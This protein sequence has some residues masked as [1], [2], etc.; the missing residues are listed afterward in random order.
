MRILPFKKFLNFL[1]LL[2][3]SQSLL[4][5]YTVNGN[6]VQISCNEYRLTQFG[7]QSGSV[8]NNNKINLTQPFDFKF[9]VWLGSPQ[10]GGAGADGIAFVLQPINTSQGG[11]GSGLGYQGISPAVGVTIDTY[12]NSSPD[13][14][15]FYDHIAIQLNGDLNHNSA[16]NI[17]GPVTAV[18]GNNDIEDGQWHSLRIVWDP[19]T[20]TF[21]TYVD[22]TLRTTVVR[23]FVATVFGNVPMVYWGFT[24]STGGE[25]NVQKFKTTL[26]PA[27]T[28][29]PTQKKCVNEPITFY[30]ATV[31]FSTIAKFYWDFGDGSP[32]DSVH[33]NPVHTYL[34]SGPFTVI[35]RVIGADGCEATN[36]QILTIGSKPVASFTFT[37]TCV[38]M[39]P[40]IPTN[41]TSTSSATVGTVNNWFWDLGNAG[42]TAITASAISSYLTA[43]DKN[44]K[45]AVKTA[46]G[47]ESDTL[48]QVVHMYGHPTA[49]FTFTDSV[50][51]GTATSFF[52]NIT[53]AAGDTAALSWKWGYN[54]G[55][56]QDI[57]IANPLHTFITP[58]LQTVLLGVFPTFIPGFGCMGFQ[59]KT[60]FVVDKPVAYFKQNTI[61]QAQTTTF[62]D[63]SYT[64]DGVAINQWWWSLGNSGVSTQQ[65]PSGIYPVSGNDTIKLVVHNEKGCVSDTLKRPVI[66]NNKPT[67]NFGYSKP[68]CSGNTV[69]FSDSSKTTAGTISKW[70]WINNGIVWSTAQNAANTFVTGLQTVQLVA[71][72]SMGCISDTVTKTF[73]IDPTPV[74]TMNFK[75]AC[76]NAMVNFTAIDSKA[77]VTQWKWTFGDG[78]TASSQ[79]ASH[80]YTANGLYKIKL[81]ATAANGCYSDSLVKDIN[82]YGTNAFAGN[83][84]VAAAGQP[85]QLNASGGLSYSWTPAYLLSDPTISNPVTTLT[86]T[87]KFTLKAFT[88]EG[89]ESYDDVLVEIY[90]G[91]EIYLP[92]AFTPNGDTR[93]DLFKG[94][95][96]GIK[97]FNYLKVFNRW[98]QLVFYS[99]D[100]NKAWDGTWKGQKQPGGVYV[101][102]ANAID[103]RGNIIDKKQ[104]VMLIR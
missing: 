93:N 100:Y 77:V 7:G 61:C 20:T 28:F 88:P 43:G 59:V 80:V 47:C 90:K 72:N 96:V 85:L 84:T 58:G 31:S 36:T 5:Q 30:D 41:F 10:P 103:F 97:Q 65:N 11:Q 8:W 21:S 54:G 3:L 23:D 12:Q 101:V 75:D 25:F 40:E 104:T 4:A 73:I 89:C 57:N 63:S 83:D 13:N 45:L 68:V 67:A 39:P 38:P 29:S 70:S 92:T 6:A 26:T 87:Q 35:Q 1:I 22:G 56:L 51:L 81:Y 55:T 79:N 86:T 14:D 18:S 62:T 76:K 2:G 16:N 98:G 50:C 82:I 64:S 24:G 17:A 69:L 66:I 91:P 74:V 71:T 49:N 94:K 15:P 34:T 32:I 95:P 44:I 48:Y 19:A 52:S 46:E 33:L 53:P 37:N 78:G 99:S 9:D 42:Q 27:F 102:M 60:V